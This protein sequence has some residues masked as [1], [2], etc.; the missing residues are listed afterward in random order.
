MPTGYTAMLIEEK[1]RSF[2]EFALTCARAFGVCIEMRDE[3]LGKEIP[4]EFKISD[5]NTEELKKAKQKL[6]EFKELTTE[7]YSKKVKG[8]FKQD[9]A[10]YEERVEKNNFTRERYSKIL[11]EAKQW[12]AP[13]TEHLGLKN[14][15]IE[16]IESS[17]DFD[18][19]EPDKPVILTGEE[20]A[21]R[22][23]SSILW[24]IEYHT[25]E[26]KAETERVESR[27]KWVKALKESLEKYK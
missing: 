8:K 7:D 11:Q 17:L 6:K 10:D 21:N 2:E 16:Q 19:Y 22:E 13:T 5:Y 14:F 23:L 26:H 27:N 12:E 15:M 9:M 24:N 1:E 20:W 25:K 18:I 3:P 4:N